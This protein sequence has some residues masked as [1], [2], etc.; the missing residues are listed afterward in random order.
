M[1]LIGILLIR[2]ELSEH[3]VVIVNIMDAG[4]EVE[5]EREL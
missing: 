5:V 1:I 2:N 3:Q 4:S